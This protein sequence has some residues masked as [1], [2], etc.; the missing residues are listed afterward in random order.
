VARL[1]HYLSR[2]VPKINTDHGKALQHPYATVEPLNKSHFILLP[3]LV[4]PEPHDLL[5]LKYEAT[6]AEIQQK[7][8]EARR[9]WIR[10]NLAA[11]GTDEDAIEA[12]GRISRKQEQPV[13]PVPSTS[14]VWNVNQPEEQL[15]T[16]F[17]EVVT[18]NRKGEEIKREKKSARYF[19]EDLGNNV[20]LEMVY[21]PGGTF[22]MGTEDEQIERLNKKYQVDWFNNE[23]PIHKV[24]LEPF[25]VSKYPITQ[26]QWYAV[27]ALPRVKR[28]LKLDPSN[29]SGNN[30]PVEQVSWFDAE[31]FCKRLSKKT[32][33]DYSL[34][35]EARWEYAC[36]AG[37]TAPFYFGETLTGELA[38]YDATKT[39]AEETKK[40][41]RQET[42]EVGQFSPNG[43]GLYDL[44]G[45]VWEW[46]E[47][48]WHKNY[49]GAL[50]NG[51][52]WIDNDS[53]SQKLKVIRGACWSSDPRVCRSAYRGDSGADG[54]NVYIG[55]RVAITRRGFFSYLAL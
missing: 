50:D 5:T 1:D 36:R 34:P 23:K 8:G 42:T 6:R 46:C 3:H 53:T 32:G 20:S 45:N 4:P 15:P 26:E 37:T 39:Y 40:V 17:F 13:S 9:L 27:A 16:F 29:F 33:K 54:V 51:K 2:R 18:V 31:E 21:I 10:V 55:L 12:F 22:W 35:S 7:W 38:N 44:H 48:D 30:R 41:F 52:A 11:A 14:G 49:Q 24:A 43:F 19:V 25:F 28:E 47:D